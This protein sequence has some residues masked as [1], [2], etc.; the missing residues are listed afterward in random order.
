LYGE[1]RDAQPAAQ[2]ETAEEWLARHGESPALLLTLG[3]LAHRTRLTDRARS[4]LEKSLALGASAAAHAELG[5]LFEEAGDS[6]RALSHCRQALELCR[7]LHH[8]VLSRP[9]LSLPGKSG[10]NDYGY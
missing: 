1:A 10:I 3:R 5:T 8:P 6:A 9:G 4:Y 2:L 7:N